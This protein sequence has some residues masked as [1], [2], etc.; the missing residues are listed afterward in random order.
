MV[1]TVDPL[2][3]AES[4]NPLT[5]AANIASRRRLYESM[6][7]QGMDSSPIRHWSQGLGRL[8]QAMVGG[9]GAY[10]ADQD[11]RGQQQRTG[12]L[13]AD[14]LVPEGPTSTLASGP[15]APS[16]TA[17]PP[18]SRAG[19]PGSPDLP[20]LTRW[21]TGQEGFQSRGFDD[22]GRRRI[23]YGTPT[24]AGDTTVTEPEARQRLEASLAASAVQIDRQFPGLTPHQR[25]ALL[26]LTYNAGPGWMTAGLGQAVRAGEWG[27][28]QELFRQYVNAGR[29]GEARRPLPGLVSRREA[30]APW[31]LPGASVPSM[32][33]GAVTAP[34]PQDLPGAPGAPPSG[35]PFSTTVPPMGFGQQWQPGGRPPTTAG[36]PPTPPPSTP[37]TSLPGAFGGIMNMMFPPA[38]AATPPPGGMPGPPG[39]MG[40][41]RGSRENPLNFEEVQDPSARRPGVFIRHPGGSIFTFDEA[42]RPV[43]VPSQ[44][45]PPVAGPPTAPP[46]MPG[47]GT[48]PSP[49]GTFQHPL[50]GSIGGGPSQVVTG[51]PPPGP[52]GGFP[53]LVGGGGGSGTRQVPEAMTPPAG[54]APPS[55]PPPGPPP[56]PP[57]TSFGAPPPGM[58]ATGQGGPLAMAGLPSSVPARPSGPPT[59]PPGGPPPG[60]Q[61]GIPGINSPALRRLLMS[62]DPQAVNFA[63]QVYRTLAS[64][65]PTA[66]YDFQAVGGQLYRINKRTGQAEPVP[67]VGG[68]QGRGQNIIGGLNELASLPGRYPRSFEGATGPLIGDPDS[69]IGGIGRRLQA[70]GAG[71][72]PMALEVRRTIEGS[73]EALAQTIKPLIRAPGEGTWSDA[74]QARLSALLGNLTQ[75]NDVTSFNRELQNV[76]QRL[77]ANFGIQ[78][79]EITFP[80]TGGPGGRQGAPPDPRG[81]FAPGAVVGGQ[82]TGQQPPATGWGQVTRE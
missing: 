36:P 26:D 21:I 15:L 66:D 16:T 73:I 59:A 9:Y 45:G 14:A 51:Q 1:T 50:F 70:M 72:G 8:T 75:A 17:G 46:S 23:G 22:F 77:M 33:S 38:G 19:A 52:Q 35:A 7:Q 61:A 58:D 57:G 32:P 30:L 69:T 53:G 41:Q 12:R 56:L 29:P 79:P 81:V 76:R 43:A 2:S 71:A 28:A 11:E 18:T 68:P 24:L 62:G 40:G 67:G 82:G 34:P 55:G 49:L 80:G 47:G 54:A 74:D 4:G 48:V 31:L 13:L 3:Y 44:D 20:D 42:G 39:G 6:L 37:S 63:L 25:A 27:R 78:L 65:Q 64:R 60:A 5:S 10:Q